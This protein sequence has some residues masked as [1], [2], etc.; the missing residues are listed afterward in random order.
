MQKS[1]ISFFK[2]N[3]FHL[4]LKE[5]NWDYRRKWIRT[6]HTRWNWW[7][8]LV[9]ETLQLADVIKTSKSKIC[10]FLD[11]VTFWRPTLPVRQNCFLKQTWWRK[12]SLDLSSTSCRL[13]HTS[14]PISINIFFSAIH[15][16]FMSPVDQRSSCETRFLLSMTSLTNF[17]ATFDKIPWF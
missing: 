3:F 1:Q 13:I 6:C 4:D 15:F 8:T 9:W 2:L 12:V 17:Y 16:L 5:S 10:L 14:Q 7:W 11:A